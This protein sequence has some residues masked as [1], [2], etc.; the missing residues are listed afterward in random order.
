MIKIKDVLSSQNPLKHSQSVG[1]DLLSSIGLS[2]LAKKSPFSIEFRAYARCLSVILLKKIKQSNGVF[3]INNDETNT[4]RNLSPPL[5]PTADAAAVAGDLAFNQQHKQA[6]YQFHLMF[7]TKS[8]TA[9]PELSHL[10]N[11]IN[12][13]L[14][15][16]TLS[17]EHFSLE[18][19]CEINMYLCKNLFKQKY[20]LFSS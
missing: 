17:G 13:Y 20:Y 19:I 3:S 11:F 8:Y 1:S 2:I 10:E 15:D 18:K 16:S 7:Q 6:A 12:Q 5:S 14:N 9:I 4:N